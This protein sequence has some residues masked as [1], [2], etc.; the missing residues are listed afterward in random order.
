M[1]VRVQNLRNL[2]Q[3]HGSVTAISKRL[4]ISP[5][6]LYRILQGKMPLRDVMARRIELVCLLPPGALDESSQKQED[7]DVPMLSLTQRITNPVQAKRYVDGKA[8]NVAKVNVD[9]DLKEELILGVLDNLEK[10]AQNKGVSLLDHQKASLLNL[11][12]KRLLSGPK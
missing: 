1:D 8:V 6:H 12:I 2:L 3:K 10:L 4:N 5:I 9:A 11:A 7:V